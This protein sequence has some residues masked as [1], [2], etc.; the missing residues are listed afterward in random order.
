MSFYYRPEDRRHE[1]YKGA[2]WTAT[3]QS[4]WR[5]LRFPHP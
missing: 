2:Q 3:I 1:V 4:E 5:D